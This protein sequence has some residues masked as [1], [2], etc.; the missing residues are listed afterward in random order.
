MSKAALNRRPTADVVPKSE[1][2]DLMEQFLIVDAECDR[3][4]KAESKQ[5]DDL[6][7]AKADVARE[8]FEEI[9]KIFVDYKIDRC[10]E[11]CGRRLIVSNGEGIEQMFAQLKKKYTERENDR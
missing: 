2:D 4:E 3:M 7:K 10:L 6:I 5:C 1:Y 9:D 11:K 8:I